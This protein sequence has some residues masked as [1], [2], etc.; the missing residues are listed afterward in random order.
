MNVLSCPRMLLLFL[1]IP[2]VLGGCSVASTVRPES[3]YD[4]VPPAA[5]DTDEPVSLFPGDAKVLTDDAIKR[6]LDYRY[7]PPALSRIA[8]MP[9]GMEMWSGWSEGLAVATEQL[10][11]DVVDALEAS[12]RVYDAAFLPSVLTP[13][14]RSV[15]HLRE[16]AARFQAD[17]MLVYR[18]F[19][20]S[21]QKYRFFRSN[22]ARAF[23]GVEAVL[24]DTRT[25]VVPLSVVASRT[26][27]VEQS[28]GDLDFRETVLKAQLAAVAGSL[29]EAVSDVVH[30]L[31]T[32]PPNEEPG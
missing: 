22:R 18:N 32:H 21:F 20:R 12:P 14:R 4:S 26:F 2:L 15:P 30:L 29:S 10:A 28:A 16:A 5:L 27:D 24:I 9:A 13:E 17:L 23:C 11:K 3:Y 31:E 7:A 1:A 6:I 8:L 19:C 25:G